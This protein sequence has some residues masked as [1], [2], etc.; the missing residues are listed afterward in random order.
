MATITRDRKCTHEGRRCT[1]NWLLRWRDADGVSR[2]KSF[3]WDKKTVANDW[4]KKVEGDRVQGIRPVTSSITFGEFAQKVIRQRSGAEGSKQRYRSV[5]HHHL[6]D[7]AD[8]KLPA[9]AQDRAGIKTLLL[10]TLPSRGVGRA[11]IA[12]SQV[13]ITSTMSEAVREGEIPS[14]NLSGIRLPA[15]DE[16]VNDELIGMCTNDIVV[17][18]ADAMPPELALT[19]WL[20]R[21]C[22]LRQSEAKAVK[23]SDFS[24]DMTI[25]TLARQ[26]E[27]G[28]SVKVL[29]SRKPGEVR[30][31]PVP[32]HVA[33]KVTRHVSEFGTHN[34]YLFTG[35]VSLFVSTSTFG[36]AFREARAAAGLPAE[37]V[38]HDLGSV[39]LSHASQRDRSFQRSKW[40]GHKSTDITSRIYAHSLPRTFEQARAFLDSEW[41]Q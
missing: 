2:E 13:V 5:L 38:Y 40:L 16:T 15:K 41:G 39:R 10:E 7:I 28:S 36:R 35:S 18:L 21:G 22:G 32:L 14:H 4:L 33:E 24:E 17:K 26:V 23:P 27:K 34:G 37:F 1:C 12:L 3:P 29:K 11:Q 30:T 25:L 31:I 8:R 9:V 20:A 19:I 6:G